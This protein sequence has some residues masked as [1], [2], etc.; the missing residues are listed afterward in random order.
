MTFAPAN[1]AGEEH[2][3]ANFSENNHTTQDQLL[4]FASKIKLGQALR[5]QYAM[6]HTK[7]CMRR[8]DAGGAASYALQD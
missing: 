2:R 1:L 7:S 3:D 6:I 4:S 8:T 5:I